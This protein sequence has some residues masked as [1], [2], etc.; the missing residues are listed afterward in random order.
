M[1]LRIII[2]FKN[3]FKHLYIDFIKY[4]SKII[5]VQKE[6]EILREYEF[7]IKINIENEEELIK[8]IF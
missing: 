6:D 7:K 4:F 5:K 1:Y 8:N 3:V 2:L